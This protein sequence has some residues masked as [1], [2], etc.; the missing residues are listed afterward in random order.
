MRVLRF[1]GQLGVMVA[2]L[3]MGATTTLATDPPFHGT[4]FVE[5]KIVTDED[6]TVFVKLEPL[7][8]GRRTMFDR[9]I[10][11]WAESDV[12][13]F[14]AE[15]DDE[16][17]M[18]VLVNAEF[19][20]KEALRQAERYLPAIGRLPRVLRD[21]VREV[22]IQGGDQ[23]FGG[24]NRSLLIHVEQGEKYL[25]QG[26]LEETLIHEAA[27]TSLDEDHAE[28]SRWIEAQR[29]DEGFIS[30]YA[31]DNPRRE[32]IAETFLLFLAWKYRADRISPELK[33]TIEKTVPHRLRYFE[34]L[35]LDLHPFVTDRS[36]K[37]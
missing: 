28:N 6:P 19:S 22:W 3:M 17:T 9:R 7:E 30:D 37:A 14:R 29:M 8:D 5:S 36:P 23:L 24:G 15:F 2:V 13:I 27:H 20:A 33:E 21:D 18:E 10:A 1:G 11:D 31:R 4:I 35:E 32:D 34:A 16:Q 26:I 12:R 25:E